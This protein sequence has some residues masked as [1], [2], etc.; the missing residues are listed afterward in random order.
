MLYMTQH[1]GNLDSNCGV[2]RPPVGPNNFSRCVLQA[3]RQPVFSIMERTPQ[4]TPGNGSRAYREVMLP[5]IPRRACACRQKQSVKG[6]DVLQPEGLQEQKLSAQ[7]R[8]RLS[9]SQQPVTPAKSDAKVVEDDTEGPCV[10]LYESV[11][12]AIAELQLQPEMEMQVTSL[13]HSSRRNRM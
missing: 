5:G 9:Y 2:K 12:E 1:V 8:R 6:V 13:H 11:D 3:Q 10:D 7:K 4:K